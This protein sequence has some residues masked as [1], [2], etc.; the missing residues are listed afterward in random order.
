MEVVV[1]EGGVFCW[2]VVDV[3]RSVTSLVAEVSF[4]CCE[5]VGEEVDSSEE[6]AGSGVVAKGN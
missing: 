4:C 1:E 2:E 3:V 5:V 6:V